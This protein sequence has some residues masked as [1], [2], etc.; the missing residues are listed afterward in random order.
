MA[1]VR[2]ILRDIVHDDQRAGAVIDRLRS[3]MK[4]E[5]LRLQPLDLNEVLGEVLDLLHSDLIQRRVSVERHLALSLPAVLADR[6]QLQQ[7]LLN[8]I[9][10]ACDAMSANAPGERRITLVTALT[11]DDAVLLAVADRGAG[12]PEGKIDRVFEPFFTS[13]EHGMG[14]G[15]AICRSIVE[16]HGGRLHAANNPDGGATFHLALPGAEPA[17]SNGTP[18]AAAVTSG[19]RSV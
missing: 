8:L 12:I 10:N 3:M 17:D 6:V 1:E 16:A 13:K 11:P 14:L 7:V 5:E 4:K 19:T 2:E 9:L 15:L 18:S